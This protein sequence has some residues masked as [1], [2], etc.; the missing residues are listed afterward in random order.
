MAGTRIS[1]YLP[2]SA[3]RARAAARKSPPW[4]STA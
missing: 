2:A 3:R 1:G 4:R